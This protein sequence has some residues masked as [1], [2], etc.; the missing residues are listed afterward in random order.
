M[1]TGAERKTGEEIKT[2][3]EIKKRLGIIFLAI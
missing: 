2:R 3:E 1:E